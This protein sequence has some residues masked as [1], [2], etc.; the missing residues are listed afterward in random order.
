MAGISGS[1]QGLANA[2][3]NVLVSM[4][5][6]FAFLSVQCQTPLLLGSQDLAQVS[7]VNR[8]Q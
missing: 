1:S 7:H 3:W 6:L 5:H 2:N 4:V 8:I